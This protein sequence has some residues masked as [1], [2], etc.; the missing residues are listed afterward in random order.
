MKKSLLA[1]LLFAGFC[2]F[3][4]SEKS[5]VNSE[6]KDVKVFVSGAQISRFLKTNIEAGVTRLAIENLSSQIDQGSITATIN[7]E[8]MVLSTS[9][10]MDYLKEKRM[11][12]ELKK[13]KDSLEILTSDM[14]ELY[15]LKSVYT[16][17]TAMLNAN[18]SIGGSNVGINADNLKK[19]IDFYR[20]RMIEVKSKVMDI[21]KKQVKLNDKITRINEQIE[22]E[23]GKINK[24]Y[25]TIL[26]DISA[27]QK[28][29]I[30]IELSYYCQ[31][32]SWKPSYDIRAKNTKS[33]V[34]LMYKANVNQNTGENW[35]KVN[36]T[37]STGNPTLGGNKPQL[38]PWFLRYY[39]PVQY[40]QDGMRQMSAPASI[41]SQLLSVKKE[42]I[43]KA[44]PDMIRMEENQLVT[45]FEIQ[46]PYTILSNSKDVLMDIQSFN[47][48]ADFA[49][50]GTPKIDKDAFLAAKITGWEKLNLLPGSSKIYLENS[51]VGESYINP[52]SALDTLLLSFGRDKRIVI[53][54][55]KVKDMNTTKFIG[56]NVEKEFLFE[57]TIRNTK[58]DDVTIT[59]D[60]Q[61]PLSTD[62]SIKISTGELSKGNYNSET[63]MINWKI[64]LKP[65]ET[66]KIRFG[67]KVKYPKDKV[68]QGL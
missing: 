54:R 28:A 42:E 4:Q 46:M 10:E 34:S 63:G 23:N 66:K 48:P 12:P 6:I 45:E 44:M 17:E 21:E 62:E 22:Q 8:A 3:A 36:V 32:A 38:Q 31:G 49:Y 26:V 20:S 59:L 35:D 16:E 57:T 1:Y 29:N 47:L 56:G 5:I 14:N 61:V 67:Y 2:A 51:Y 43:V 9:F 50:Y 64:D 39:V 15:M 52:A 30:E 53:K 18:K 33:E 40:R 7:G 13:L 41:E 25:G 60:D 24:P 65:G 37:L 55:D 19:A 27:K 58:K 68:I 11:S